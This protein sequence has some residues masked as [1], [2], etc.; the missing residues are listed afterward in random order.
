MLRIERRHVKYT[1]WTLYVLAA[2]GDPGFYKVGVTRHPVERRIDRLQTGNPRQLVCVRTRTYE[3]KAMMYAAET[4]FFTYARAAGK[5][6]HNEWVQT[7]LEFIESAL[8]AIDAM[9]APY[10][11]PVVTSPQ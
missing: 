2:I 7:D 9:A 4:A 3:N 11:K 10:R 6:T 1:V 5:P 8:D